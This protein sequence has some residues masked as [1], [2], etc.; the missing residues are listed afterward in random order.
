MRRVV[1]YEINEALV[2]C[3]WVTSFRVH[4]RCDTSLSRLAASVTRAFTFQC[5]VDATFETRLKFLIFDVVTASQIQTIFKHQINHLN[6]MYFSTSGSKSA[7]LK[8]QMEKNRMQHVKKI[9]FNF[10]F[11]FNNL[12][13]T[14]KINFFSPYLHNILL[15]RT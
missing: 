7:F 3:R 9:Y 11:Y 1:D 8:P 12:F 2:T 4:C 10:L 15:V 14:R 13:Y 6:K 5:V